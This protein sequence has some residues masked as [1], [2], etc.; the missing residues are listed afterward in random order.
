MIGKSRQ[1]GLTLM[2]LKVY[3][4]K[5]KIKIEFGIAKGRK[6]VDKREIIKKRE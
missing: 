2:P 5:G 4:K 3:T 1:K 6:K